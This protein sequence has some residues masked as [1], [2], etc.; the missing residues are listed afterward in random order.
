MGDNRTEGFRRL[1]NML[2]S[3]MRCANAGDSELVRKRF[4][5]L[6]QWLGAN[7]YGKSG[8]EAISEP[9]RWTEKQ[10]KAVV[11][12][13]RDFE[14]RLANGYTLVAK[15]MSCDE[16]VALG[17]EV[18]KCGSEVLLKAAEDLSKSGRMSYSDALVSVA[19]AS[20]GLYEAHV[21]S[22][23]G[24]SGQFWSWRWSNKE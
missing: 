12:S 17:E 11:G 19:K 1:L 15:A 18:D 2:N 20:P 7:G 14:R 6:T 22:V 5:A 24:Q 9:E 4:E 21:R 23:N 13:A 3:L 16:A 8:G 10:V